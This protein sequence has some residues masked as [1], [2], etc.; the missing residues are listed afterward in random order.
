MLLL[1]ICFF[2]CVPEDVVGEIGEGEKG[3]CGGEMSGHLTGEQWSGKR[4]MRK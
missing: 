3:G 1:G 2:S 4:K